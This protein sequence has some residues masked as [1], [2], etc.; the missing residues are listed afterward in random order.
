LVVVSPAA[1]RGSSTTDARN[2]R[3]LGTPFS[4]VPVG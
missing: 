2:S 4:T 3:L 1:K